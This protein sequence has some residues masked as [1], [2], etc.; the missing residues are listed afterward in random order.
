M[1]QKLLIIQ[2]TAQR[3]LVKLQKI[4]EAPEAREGKRCER[5][6]LLGLAGFK[7]MLAAHQAGACDSQLTHALLMAVKAGLIGARQHIA[8][9]SACGGSLRC[10]V[11][12]LL[13]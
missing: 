3:C 12:T 11:Q 5:K 7:P 4:P 6:V 8:V 13:D 2:G 10:R 1:E 9:W